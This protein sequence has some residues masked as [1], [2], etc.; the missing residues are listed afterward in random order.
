MGHFHTEPR[1]NDQPSAADYHSQAPSANWEISTQ[2]RRVPTRVCRL[3]C[4]QENRTL[5][6]HGTAR[7]SV[8]CCTITQ[9]KSSYNPH[10]PI[11]P[12]AR[13]T[14]QR[15]PTTSVG[16]LT[17]IW[18]RFRYTSALL[19]DSIARRHRRNRQIRA[20]PRSWPAD[21]WGPARIRIQP[22]LRHRAS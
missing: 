5:P 14:T 4:W 19:N 20:S 13:S 1:S 17:D 11:T 2:P 7:A 12:T 16:V 9:L 6:V 15:T 21:P 10:S 22:C 8:H 3:R 18:Y